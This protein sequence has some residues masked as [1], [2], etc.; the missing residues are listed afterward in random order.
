MG[1]VAVDALKRAVLKSNTYWLD[2]CEDHRPEAFGA[3]TRLHSYAAC[4]EQD[5]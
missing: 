2:V 5:C 1:V 4:I 3:D